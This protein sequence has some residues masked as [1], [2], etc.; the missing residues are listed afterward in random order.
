MLPFEGFFFFFSSKNSF[1]KLQNLQIP[2]FVF[3]SKAIKD[4]A[5][6]ALIPQLRETLSQLMYKVQAALVGTNCSSIFWAGNLKNKDLHGDEILSQV[7]TIVKCP[8]IG[9]HQA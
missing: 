6:I 2:H 3:F 9:M 7:R 8:E 5:I 1:F 4:T